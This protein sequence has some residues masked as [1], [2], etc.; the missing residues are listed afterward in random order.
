MNDEETF[1]TWV[2]ITEEPVEK[3]YYDLLAMVARTMREAGEDPDNTEL[4]AIRA[5][6]A[7]YSLYSRTA[8][9]NYK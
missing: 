8:K 6:Q 3:L 7:G 2:E 9:M 4:F 1:A 5:G